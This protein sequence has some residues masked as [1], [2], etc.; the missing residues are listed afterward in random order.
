M[1]EKSGQIV[2]EMFLPVDIG[3]FML[4]KKGVSKAVDSALVLFSHQWEAEL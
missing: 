3:Q 1:R 4:G 2:M